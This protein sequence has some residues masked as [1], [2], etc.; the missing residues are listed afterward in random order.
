MH[1]PFIDPTRRL[2]VLWAFAA[3]MALTTA[4]AKEPMHYVYPQAESDADQRMNYYWELLEAVLDETTPRWGPYTLSPT[5]KPM[6][7]A[8]SQVQLMASKEVQVIVRTTSEE[9][10]TQM[11]AIR[12]PL[13]KGL[14]GYRLFLT[15]KAVERD[16][17]AVKTLSDLRAFSVG[18][19]V[20]WIDA[21]ILRAAGLRVVTA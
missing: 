17:K 6:N 19:G 4:S 16:L 11:R 2:S 13:D 1:R 5:A 20:N 10:E 14:T 8:R 15:R 7:S 9:R 3:C 12:L 21:S 18:Q